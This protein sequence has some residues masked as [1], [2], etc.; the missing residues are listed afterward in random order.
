MTDLATTT[1]EGAATTPVESTPAADVAA[2]TQA[3]AADG[4]FAA[5]ETTEPSATTDPEAAADAADKPET[6]KPKSR[7]S[8]RIN[9]LT[10]EKNA[11]MRRAAVA[12][13]RYNELRRAPAPQVD[14]N[15]FDAVQRESMRGVIRE[16]TAQQ[17]V[18]EHRQAVQDARR[19]QAETFYAKVEAARERIPDID[20]TIANFGRLPLS[21]EV[22][23]LIAESDVAAELAHHISLNPRIVDE[24]RGLSPA[25]Q[26]RA[27]ARIEAKLSLPTRRTSTAPPPT[28]SVT[29]SGAPTARAPSEMSI[30]DVQASL[31]KSGVIR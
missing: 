12:E 8:E 5:V 19:A 17:V 10:A 15:D 20:Q 28:P 6:E 24:L 31:R 30:A 27:L 18:T 23:E 3:R 1:P 25:Q 29:G 11:A 4:K 16:E 14:P 21:D 22:C 7:A 13:Q 26:G 9:Q 2:T